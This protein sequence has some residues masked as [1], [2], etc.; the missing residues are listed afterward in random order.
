MNSVALELFIFEKT[1]YYL[2]ILDLKSRDTSTWVPIVLLYTPSR[3][4]KKKGPVLSS[5]EQLQSYF[6]SRDYGDYDDMNHFLGS[7]RKAVR[8]SIGIATTKADIYRLIQFVKKILNGRQVKI[9]F[10][11][12]EIIPAVV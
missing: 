12:S 9:E 7:M 3:P 5:A 8:I 2:H 6:I 4:P 10:S 1:I 11:R